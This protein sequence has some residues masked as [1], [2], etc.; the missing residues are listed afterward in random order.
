MAGVDITGFEMARRKAR[1]AELN[2]PEEQVE[3]AEAQEEVKRRGR[4]PKQTEESEGL[5]AKVGE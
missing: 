2:V 5:T 1:A 3:E 4:P